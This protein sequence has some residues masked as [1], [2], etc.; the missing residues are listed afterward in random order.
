MTKLEPIN[1]INKSKLSKKNYFTS[2]IV[3]GQLCSLLSDSDIENIQFQCLSLLVNQTEKYNHGTSSSIRVEKAEDL[4]SSILYTLG[5]QLKSYP[6]PE[7]AINALKQE[8][9]KNLFCLGLK[10]IKRKMQTSQLIHRQIKQNF[11]HTKNV[12][13]HSTVIDGINGFFKLYNSEFSAQEIHITADYPTFN[14]INDLAGIEFIEKYLQNIS[15]ENKFCLYF[16]ENTVHHLLCGLDENYQQILMNIYEPILTAALGCVLT[17]E[18]IKELYCNLKFLKNL[19]LGK[20]KEEI[21]IILLEALEKIISEFACSSDLSNYLK[22]SID[23]IATTIQNAI[24]NDHLETVFLVPS[25]PEDNPQLILSYGE[26]MNDI[27]YTKVL[28]EI[29]LCDDTNY[30]AEI[31]I[32]KI[33]SLGD[34]LEVLRD[35]ELTELE[36]QTIFKKFPLEII[37]ALMGQYPNNDFLSDECENRIYY[38]LQD[39]NKSLSKSAR[40]KLNKAVKALRFYT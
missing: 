37:A 33:H 28:D 24:K 20:T 2:L 38:A 30:K 23:K 6:S 36:L 14:V 3:Q 31:I 18:P 15:Y 11:F 27:A 29:M 35:A 21:N 10:K 25:Y 34:L 5:I 26:R 12:F 16:S 1:I 7:D 8:N 40:E 9:I 13:Y 32:N 4:L 39:F 17:N 19:F 22:F